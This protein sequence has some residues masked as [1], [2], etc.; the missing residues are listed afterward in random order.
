[1]IDIVYLANTGPCRKFTAGEDIPCPG[2]SGDSER[3]MY[4][5]LG[6]RVDVSRTIPAGRRLA[7]G[8]LFP[9]D[10][11]G[12]HEFFT[13]IDEY[14]YSAG[15]DSVVYIITESSFDELSW[16]RS[17]IL[18]EVL[19]A[20]YA[21]SKRISAP[22]NTAIAPV[23]NESSASPKIIG[24][25]KTRAKPVNKVKTKAS[26]QSND[27]AS[28]ENLAVMSAI[29]SE[30]EIFPEGHKSYPGVT[31]PEYAQLVFP[32]DYD[33]PFC[34]KPFNDYKVF[35]SKL[36]EAAPMRFDLRRYYTDFQTEWYDII[37][38]HNCL[39]S[40]FNNYF[41]EPKP[42]Q[43]AKIEHKLAAVRASILL[44]F[45]AERDIDFVMTAHYL[46]L[47]CAD[48]YLSIGKQIRAKLWGNLSWLYEDV[49]DDAM[50]KFAAGKAAEAYETVYTETVLTP[51]QE[52]V[53]CLSI[54][55]MQYRAGTDRNLKKYLF[56]AKTAKMGDKT[57]AK[58]AE[59]F[60]FELRV[61]DE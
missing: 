58:L 48:G 4:V 9:G 50:A 14:F 45:E 57:Y 59:D 23:A 40:M 47:I 7:V 3:E 18:F 33:C 49:E 12:G 11:F 27:L 28:E 20:A 29:L 37:T 2:G 52:Q 25:P 35:R 32:K 60:M 15:V 56:T 61:E 17:D 39:F 36:F 21:S 13:G 51:V 8:S 1:M 6:G 19:R 22:A 43:K 30:G 41:S 38:C 42:I 46:A 55:G 53:T 24:Y 34:K 10:I 5:L 31:K 54:A 26:G 44:D 16:T